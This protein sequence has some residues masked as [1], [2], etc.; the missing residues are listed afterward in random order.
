MTEEIKILLTEQEA[1][2]LLEYV[3]RIN[4][5]KE[6]REIYEQRVL[7]NLETRLERAIPFIFDKRY[8]EVLEEAKKNI[9]E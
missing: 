5:S 6:I 2:V 7:W 9:Q 8:G 4:A 1:V 3:A